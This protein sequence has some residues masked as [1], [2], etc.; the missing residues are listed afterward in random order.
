MTIRFKAMALV[1]LGMLGAMPAFADDEEGPYVYVQAGGAIARNACQSGWI[2]TALPAYGSN[3]G[4]SERSQVYRAGFGYQFTSMWGLEVNYGT[5]GN[6]K[7]TG[8]ALLPVPGYAGPS[9]YSWQLKAAGL[10]VEGVGT[11]HLSDSLAV[12][13][14]AGVAQVEFTEYMYSWDPAI[15]GNV[16]NYYWVP[17]VQTNRNALALG[18]GIKY[19][20]GPH[21]SIFLIAESFGSHA[22]YDVY[23]SNAKVRLVSASVGLMYRY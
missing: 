17:V 7:A 6:A 8:S 5:F 18:A 14:K 1:L 4:C 11:L 23:G 10:A 19:E 3:P 15:S 2:T 20:F 22:I 13:G 21:G 16:T 12:I 9:N